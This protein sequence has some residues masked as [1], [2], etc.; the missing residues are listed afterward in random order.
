MDDEID[1]DDVSSVLN[2][3]RKIKPKHV[4]LILSLCLAVMCFFLGY[5]DGFNEAYHALKEEH[6]EYITKYCFCRDVPDYSIKPQLYDFGE[7]NLS[8]NNIS[9]N[10]KNK[11]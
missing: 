3:L 7:L 2:G 9:A 5:I 10:S 11:K 6:S 1:S 4:L 8:N